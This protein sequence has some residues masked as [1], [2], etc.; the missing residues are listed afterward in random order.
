MLTTQKLSI[1]IREKAHMK[2][3]RVK[4]APVRPGEILGGDFSR[5]SGLSINALA[6]VAPPYSYVFGHG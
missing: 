2:A 1:V 6:R 3:N 4:M 5:P